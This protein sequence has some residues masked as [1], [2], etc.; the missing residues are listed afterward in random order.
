M[1]KT[2]SRTYLKN[3]RSKA[4]KYYFKNPDSTL[5]SLAAKFKINQDKLSKDISTKLEKRFNNR[6]ARK[7]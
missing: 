6:L 4:V 5:K 7:S 3:Q 1:R 2:R